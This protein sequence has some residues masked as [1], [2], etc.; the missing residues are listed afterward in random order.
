MRAASE[1][2]WRHGDIADRWPANTPLTAAGL[3]RGFAPPAS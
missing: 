3:A 1:A 2:V